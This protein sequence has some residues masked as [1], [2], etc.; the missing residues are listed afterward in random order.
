MAAP[1][2]SPAWMLRILKTPW[3]SDSHPETPERYLQLV[4]QCLH[5]VQ[6]MT[7]EGSNVKVHH[8]QCRYLVHKLEMVVTLIKSKDLDTTLPSSSHVY[9]EELLKVSKLLYQLVNEMES[10]I[11]NCCKDEWIQSAM[12][13]SDVSK[14]VATRAFQL[15][16]LMLR[17]HKML[18]SASLT[19]ERTEL[20]SLHAE[21]FNKVQAAASVDRGILV[22]RLEKVIY[23]SNILKNEQFYLATYVLQRLEFQQAQPASR[24]WEVEYGSLQR[25]ETLGKGTMGSTELHK[26]TWLGAE[27]AEKTF[28][29]EELYPIFLNEVSILQRLSHSNVVPLLCYATNKIESSIVMELMDSDLHFL[30]QERFQSDSSCKVPFTLEESVD[31]MLQVAEAMKHIHEKRILHRDLKSHNI[32][33]KYEKGKGVLHV[34]VADFGISKEQE[35]SSTCSCQS[36]NMGTTRW[37]APEVIAAPGQAQSSSGS[38]E[39]PK[40][41]FKSDIYS[42]GMLCYEILTGKYPFWDIG[43]LSQVKSKILRGK[44]PRLPH[45]CPEDLK[46]LI[47]RCWKLEASARPSFAEICKELQYLQ[48]CIYL[49]MLRSFLVA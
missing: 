11:L 17:L 32:L 44:Q 37:M 43:S 34:K 13:L 16:L 28:F 47:V 36:M 8:E 20:E 33:V 18:G 4:K 38:V 19:P 48:W 6:E 25:K 21:E 10:F 45:L 14:H 49:G 46:T 9:L 30:I 22:K 5:Q 40:Y 7:F 1:R 3:K 29:G 23:D 41:P 42:F 26:A 2:S 15:E 24:H 12:I 39:V 31:I 35:H 27:L